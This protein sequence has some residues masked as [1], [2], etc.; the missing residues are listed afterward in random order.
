MENPLS[1]VEGPGIH[2]SASRQQKRKAIFAV[3]HKITGVPNP[4][5]NNILSEP[6]KDLSTAVRKI[7]DQENDA[8]PIR[9]GKSL[10][11]VF[12][13]L[14]ALD[15]YDDI[16]GLPGLFR[17]ISSIPP[18]TFQIILAS[19]D[20]DTIRSPGIDQQQGSPYKGVWHR[21]GSSMMPRHLFIIFS[22]SIF[23]ISG[24]KEKQPKDSSRAVIRYSCWRTTVSSH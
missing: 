9:A 22:Y 6:C 23:P 18:K 3:H 1:H 14:D 4:V 2:S 5:S 10:G 7:P 15:E 13:V 19:R 20:M 16:H 24:V 12:S 11:K 8:I 17:D 21:N